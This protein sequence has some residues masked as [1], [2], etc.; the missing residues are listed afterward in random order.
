MCCYSREDCQSEDPLLCV[1]VC[2][3]VCV[4]ERREKDMKTEYEVIHFIL[5]IIN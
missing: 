4:R 5:K 2:V 1:C 3:H